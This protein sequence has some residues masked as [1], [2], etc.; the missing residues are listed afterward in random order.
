M[1]EKILIVD[2]EKSIVDIIKF[3][4]DKEGYRTF[5][6]Y[7]GYGALEQFQKESPDL[8]ILDVMMPGMD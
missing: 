8:V 6:A 1:Y 4:L 5:T 3:N 2:D 7:D